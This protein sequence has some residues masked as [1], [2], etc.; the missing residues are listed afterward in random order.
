MSSS[1]FFN[2]PAI[3]DAL[4]TE[5][6]KLNF[7]DDPQF[8]TLIN[9][10]KSDI[11]NPYYHDRNK[12]AYTRILL[13]YLDDYLDNRYAPAIATGQ[14]SYYGKLTQIFHNA[15]LEP[16]DKKVPL[17]Y[18]PKRF[19]A[20]FDG[21]PKDETRPNEFPDSRIL[22][23]IR[24]EDIT[25]LLTSHVFK[26]KFS[27]G[28]I[29]KE[30][31]DQLSINCDKALYRFGNANAVQRA[32]DGLVKKKFGK[33][34]E[35]LLKTES[36]NQKEKAITARHK[37]LQA[38]AYLMKKIHEEFWLTN[39]INVFRELPR[40]LTDKQNNAI[41]DIIA[42]LSEFQEQHDLYQ[43][44]IHQ[45]E[46][47][48]LIIKL[49]IDAYLTDRQQAFMGGSNKG[50]YL[51]YVEEVLKTF[52]QQTDSTLFHGVGNTFRDQVF[53]S[54]NSN[55]A[56]FF[57]NELATTAISTLKTATQDEVSIQR[58]KDIYV[59]AAKAAR[60]IGQIAI[61]S[62]NETLQPYN[63]ADLVLSINHR[64]PTLR[65]AVDR[66]LIAKNL[67]KMH[68]H[69]RDNAIWWKAAASSSASDSSS[70]ATSAS[71]ART[72]S[73][74][75]PFAELHKLFTPST[76]QNSYEPTPD[77]KVEEQKSIS[78]TLSKT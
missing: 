53:G 66:L 30:N 46:I 8:I 72:F 74:L 47:H 19:M 60:G 15:F 43:N 76:Y 39:L 6:K 24:D 41:E 1:V 3:I 27:E 36:A 10:L 18:R 9:N 61:D 37:R 71:S 17:A 67:E 69:D 58:A 31:S 64:E 33:Q 59:N 34:P 52:E 50:A 54:V 70:T 75:T 7:S 62:W 21:E 25:Q 63:L 32:W 48:T 23:S 77:G 49:Y 40:N 14:G 65:S 45:E 78:P 56:K 38:T 12:K 73:P 13:A 57:G 16:I 29:R 26:R 5:A 51:R 35:L 11:L 4:E 22:S 20:K 2:I 68:K 42:S 44:P 55:Q 28:F